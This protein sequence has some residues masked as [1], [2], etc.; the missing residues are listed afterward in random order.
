MNDDTSMTQEIEC[1]IVMPCLNEQKTISICIEKAQDALDR[2]GISGEIIVADNGSTDGSPAIAERLS[3]R[4]VHQPIRG[5]GSA[6]QACMNVAKG[7][8]I[9]MGDSDD[10]Y[11]FGDFPSLNPF[12]WHVIQVNRGKYP[13]PV[14]GE[15]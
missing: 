7:K 15:S 9:I 3:A 1:S 11:D 12:G 10:T 2:L 4:V 14:H 6:Y 13:L 5:Y 8:Y